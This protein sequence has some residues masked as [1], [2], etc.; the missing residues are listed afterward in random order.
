MMLFNLS[1][2]LAQP[3]NWLGFPSVCDLDPLLSGILQIFKE[4]TMHF[5]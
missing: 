2:I 1:L 5:V 3:A 4:T